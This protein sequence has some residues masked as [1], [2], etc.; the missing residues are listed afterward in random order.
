MSEDIVILVSEE[1]CEREFREDSEV[2]DNSNQF[3][4]PKVVGLEQILQDMEIVEQAA[5]LD[6]Q[7][8]RVGTYD[9]VEI[10]N[11]GIL[12]THLI[13]KKG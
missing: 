3:K 5:F 9:S 1:E 13:C 6:I 7:E 12:K 8:S 4:W 10:E 2:K 11:Q